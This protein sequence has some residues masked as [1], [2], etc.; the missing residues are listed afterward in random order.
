[1]ERKILKGLKIAFEKQEFD[2]I[3]RE[4]TRLHMHG[5]DPMQ[6]VRKA[7]EWSH[8][9][10]EFGFLHS[11]AVTA[12]WLTLAKSFA[13]KTDGDWEPQLIC[14]SESMDH[15]A[16]NALRHPSYPYP[17]TGEPFESE[18]F[19][20]AVEVE[21]HDRAVGMVVRGLAD[22]LHWADMHAALPT[23]RWPL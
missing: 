2:R 17:E 9:R 23:P 4:L 8:D 1:M 20:D 19:I 18:A 7:I 16:D 12:D 5:L 13:H 10:F 14:L 6:G 22:G 21:Q 3:C 11:Y 15:M